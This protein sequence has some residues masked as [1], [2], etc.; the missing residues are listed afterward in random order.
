[1]EVTQ[2]VYINMVNNTVFQR[3]HVKLML[4]RTQINSAVQISKNV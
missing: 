1:M 3:K 4:P 2:L